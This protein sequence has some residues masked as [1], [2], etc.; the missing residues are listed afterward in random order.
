MEENLT[1]WTLKEV[2]KLTEIFNSNKINHLL[3]L[4]ESKDVKI[5]PQTQEC[6]EKV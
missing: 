3:E 4:S 6:P 1:E 5:P 2:Q